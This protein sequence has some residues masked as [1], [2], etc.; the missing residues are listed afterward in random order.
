MKASLVLQTTLVFLFVFSCALPRKPEKAKA[1]KEA[2]QVNDYGIQLGVN[3]DTVLKVTYTGCGGLI[4]DYDGEVVMVDPFFSNKKLGRLAISEVFGA[5]NLRSDITTIENGIDSARVRGQF[6]NTKAVLIAHSHYDHLL[7][8]PYLESEYFKKTAAQYF[9][10][11]STGLALA[12]IITD[13]SR[14]TYL[15]NTLS[16]QWTEGNWL[17]ISDRIK[18]LPVK[19]SH[20][21]HFA[22]MSF[23]NG[24][25]HEPVE[26]LENAQSS[27]S[28][29]DWNVGDTYAFLLE[30]E[31][32][33]KPLR[34][35]IASSSAKPPDGIPNKKWIDQNPVDLAFICYASSG[36]VADYPVRLLNEI[37]PKKVVLFHWEDFF[38][39]YDKEEKMVKVTLR[40]KFRRR[41]E[42]AGYSWDNITMPKKGVTAH[43]TL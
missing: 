25:I 32:K 11:K 26:G 38:D 9:C 3:N 4:L 18:L 15:C 2:Y 19:S 12:N 7:D 35:Y 8:I 37:K 41:I 29:R 30:F 27:T 20:A 34:V 33:P 36:Q 14:F 5:K 13:D 28:L 24:H 23:M 22:R 21:P 10:S 1:F 40:G 31:A 17:K 39:D 16:D 6:N 43:I 42:K